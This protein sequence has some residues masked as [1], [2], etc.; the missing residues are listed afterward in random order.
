MTCMFFLERFSSFYFSE[1]DRELHL[2][3]L[4]VQSIE[5]DIEIKKGV[6]VRSSFLQR[7]RKS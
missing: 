2:V 5:N 6:R 3:D 4:V 1:E 7:L